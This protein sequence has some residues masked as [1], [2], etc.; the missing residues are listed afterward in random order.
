[1]RRVGYDYDYYYDDTNDINNGIVLHEAT[2]GHPDCA[3]YRYDYG[4]TRELN[5][6]HVHAI[7]NG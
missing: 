1:M 4:T 3:G 6:Q 7:T 5:T 2:A